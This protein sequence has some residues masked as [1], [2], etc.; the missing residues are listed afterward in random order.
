[1]T[2]ANDGIAGQGREE[3]RRKEGAPIE[4]K[5]P[6]NQILNTP[7]GLCHRYYLFYVAI[8]GVRQLGTVQVN[9]L[10]EVRVIGDVRYVSHIFA[11]LVCR[12]DMM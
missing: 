11:I 6:P 7:L 12:C 8:V 2:F 1:M 10:A 4:M 5:A 9:V 3:R